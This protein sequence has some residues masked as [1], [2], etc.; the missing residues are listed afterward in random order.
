MGSRQTVGRVKGREDAVVQTK[1]MEEERA[2]QK[3]LWLLRHADYQRPLLGG[4][5]QR[6]IPLPR[7]S[8]SLP[9]NFLCMLP[10]CPFPGSIS[11]AEG[12]PRMHR[13]FKENPKL[14]KPESF[15]KDNL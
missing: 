13:Q 3:G 10:Q 6:I 15:S 7:V 11:S 9:F 12:V 14:S 1:T 8:F 5:G 4:G 2:P